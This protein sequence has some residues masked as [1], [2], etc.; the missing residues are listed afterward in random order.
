MS[1]THTLFFS[2]TQTGANVAQAFEKAIKQFVCELK[3]KINERN[4]P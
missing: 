3:T 1:Q 4:I 2:P